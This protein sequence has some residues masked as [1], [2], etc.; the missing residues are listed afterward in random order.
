MEVGTP[1]MTQVGTHLLPVIPPTLI[2]FLY[3][4]K[5]LQS[6]INLSLLIPDIAYLESALFVVLSSAAPSPTSQGCTLV[7]VGVAYG[8]NLAC[9]ATEG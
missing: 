9:R 5:S 3:R 2:K 4:D 7:G 8:L 6:L 1:G